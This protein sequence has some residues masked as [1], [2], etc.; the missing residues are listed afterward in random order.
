M[1]ATN[2]RPGR[3]QASR[4]LHRPSPGPIEVVT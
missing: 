3:A 4:F 2:R 1:R